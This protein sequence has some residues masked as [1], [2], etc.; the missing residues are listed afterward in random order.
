MKLSKQTLKQIIKE[1]LDAVMNNDY[2]EEADSPTMAHV[3]RGQN[4][5]VELQYDG[6]RVDFLYRYVKP[7]YNPDSVRNAVEGLAAKKGTLG[8]VN[9]LAE[10]IHGVLSQKMDSDVPTLEQLKSMKVHIS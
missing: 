4:D 8:Q 7:K 2:L 3:S 9:G 5:R 6:K 10:V 1:E